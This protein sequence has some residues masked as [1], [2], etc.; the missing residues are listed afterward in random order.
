MAARVWRMILTICATISVFVATATPASAVTWTVDDLSDGIQCAGAQFTTIS[1]AV[2]A[3]SINPL[4]PDIIIVCDGDYFEQ[5]VIDRS[6]T[7]Q[8][9]QG[10]SPTVHFPPVTTEPNK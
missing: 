9:A 3:S 7:L 4:L 5:V 6:L 2:A 1:A 10:Q 8:A